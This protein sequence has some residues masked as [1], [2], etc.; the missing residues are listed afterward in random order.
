MLIDGGVVK[1]VLDKYNI[2]VT[3]VLHIGSHLC[4]EKQFYNTT[5]KVSDDNIVWVDANPNLVQYTKDCGIKNVYHAALDKEEKEQVLHIANNGQSSSLLDFG[6]HSSYYNHIVYVGDIKV[7]TQTLSSFYEDNK[8]DVKKY[9]FYNLDIQGKE[10]DVLMGSKELLINVDA[11]YTEVNSEEVYKNCG[12]I[13]E[14]DKLLSEYK[15]K[16]VLTHF[17]EHKWGDA[18]YVKN[19]A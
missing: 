7:T 10:Y 19:L 14:L 16:R 6:T 3:G 1:N 9:N 4:E 15:F 18:L 2:K 5:L 17:T 13:E 11:I 8:L 12:L